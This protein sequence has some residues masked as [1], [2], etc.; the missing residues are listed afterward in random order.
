MEI[1]QEMVMHLNFGSE[2]HGYAYRLK[3]DDKEIGIR[4][5]RTG[6][7][8]LDIVSIGDEEFDVLANGQEAALAWINARCKD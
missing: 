1:T 8:P 3:A 7:E 6:K 2:G 5:V 4:N